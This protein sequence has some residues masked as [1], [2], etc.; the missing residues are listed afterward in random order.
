MYIEDDVWIASCCVVLP[1]C[2]IRKGSVI[3]AGAVVTCDTEAYGV[4]A[5]NPARLI[6]KRN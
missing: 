4:Y 6:K 5:G 2:R 3:A 1:G